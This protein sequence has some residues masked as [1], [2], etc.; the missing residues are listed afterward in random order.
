MLEGF[1]LKFI[2]F[3]DTSFDLFVSNV[4]WELVARRERLY[5]EILLLMAIIGDR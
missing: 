4:V 3:D 1:K 5:D 2:R